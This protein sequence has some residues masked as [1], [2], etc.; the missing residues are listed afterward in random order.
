MASEVTTA[1]LSAV[2]EKQKAYQEGLNRH[3]TQS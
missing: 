2:A 1:D 3:P